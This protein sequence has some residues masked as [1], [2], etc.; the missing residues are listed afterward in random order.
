MNGF[1]RLWNGSTKGSLGRVH[2]VDDEMEVKRK[3]CVQGV[4]R[5]L[6]LQL[7]F[8]K[9]VDDQADPKYALKIATHQVWTLLLAKSF[10]QGRC[11]LCS[12]SFDEGTASSLEAPIA[13][14]T[15]PRTPLVEQRFM[16]SRP[17]F[18]LWVVQLLPTFPGDIHSASRCNQ[19]ETRWPLPST[20]TDIERARS[21]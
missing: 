18:P 15:L 20:C 6:V 19:N 21:C 9:A 13:S 3:M 17:M 2:I 10:C 12:A 4:A 14:S 16:T 8:P 7:R 1:L 11:C 5:P